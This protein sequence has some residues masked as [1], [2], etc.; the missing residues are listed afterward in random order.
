MTYKDIEIGA[1]GQGVGEHVALLQRPRHVAEPDVPLVVNDPGR[2]LEAVVIGGTLQHRRRGGDGPLGGV[3]REHVGPVVLGAGV[4]VQRVQVDQGSQ[5]VND[6]GVPV[7]PAQ[8]PAG[9]ELGPGVDHPDRPRPASG[10]GHVLLGRQRPH[11]PR[12]VDLIAE[13][14]PRHAVRR[15]VAALASAVGPV[16]AAVV[17]A[18]L[19]PGQGLFQRAAA[20]VETEVGLGPELGA[21]LDELV[22]AEAVW[23][24]ASP[25]QVGAYGAGPFG[26]D[27]VLPVVVGHE[28]A[29]RPAQHAEA[30]LL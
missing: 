20:H 13:A 11:L 18:V 21:V 1:D 28:V 7:R 15:T 3:G 29:P 8:F 10:L 26:A 30:Q 23:L 14:P 24:G 16:G 25:G 17:V 6:L 5:P 12:A 22:G 4:K 2:L 9:H 19:D 27:A